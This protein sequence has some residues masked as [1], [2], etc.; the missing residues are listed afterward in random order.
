MLTNLYS[1]KVVKLNIIIIIII[2]IKG[3]CLL[4]FK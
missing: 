4:V 2:I 3:K 1:N